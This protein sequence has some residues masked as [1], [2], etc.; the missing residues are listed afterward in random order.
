MTCTQHLTEELRSR[1]YRI[2]PQRTAILAYLHDTPGHSSPAEIYEH[3]RQTTSG[4]TEA[5]VYRTLEIL[6]DLGL[7]RKLHSDAG[8]H[9][10]A[11][12]I[13]DHGHHVI[14]QACGQ[15]VEFAGCDIA[16]VVAAVEVQTGFRVQ[17]HW[18]EMF[19]LCPECR[20]SEG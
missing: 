15:A 1:G 18:L 8:C 20:K 7:V 16:A 19:G 17:T 9:A 14:C 13:H 2:T 12:A 11:P 4:V 3:V 10:Y 6:H 5:T